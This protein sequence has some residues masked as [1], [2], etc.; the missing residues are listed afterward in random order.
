MNNYFRLKTHE[1]LALIDESAKLTGADVVLHTPDPELHGLT[2]DSDESDNE[3]LGN[4]NHL[5]KG[6]LNALVYVVSHHSDETT[7]MDK[8]L[9]ST[10][11]LSS[12][13][14]TNKRQ[15]KAEVS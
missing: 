15:K 13:A 3:T 4:V 6:L 11:G 8:A 2:E 5:A 12:A 9:P 1:V 7:E 10:S 14:T